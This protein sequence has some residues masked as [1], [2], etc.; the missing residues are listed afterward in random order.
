MKKVFSIVG[1]FL[2]LFSCSIYGQLNYKFSAGSGTFTPITGAS[3]FTWNLTTAN[4]EEYSAATDIGF[5]FT[6]AGTEY[7]QF[8]VSTNG[9]LRF[10]GSGLTAATSADA[11]DGSLRQIVAPLWDNLSVGLTATDITYLREGSEPNRVLTVEWKNVK[12]NK[13]ASAVN[14]QFQVKLYEG[15][16]KIEFVYGNMV[17]PASVSASIG[18]VDNTPITTAG[19]ATG[20]FL[21]I[22]VGGTA[23]ARTYHQTMSIPFSAISNAPDPNTVFTFE[24]VTKTPIAAGTYTIGGT[25]PDYKTLSDAATAL[26]V[27]GVAGPVVFKVREGT[28]DDIFHLIAVEGTSET[29]T[30]TLMNESGTVVLSPRNGSSGSTSGGYNADGIIRLDGTQYATIQ[31]LTL[32]D[33]GQSSTQLKFEFGVCVGNS[34]LNNRMAQGAKFNHLKDL[35]IDMKPTTGTTHSGAIGIRYFT[36]W[37]TGTNETDTSMTTSYNTIENCTFKGYWRAG[38][39]TFGVSGVNPDRGNVIKGCTFGD[40]SIK[41]GTGSDIRTMEIDCENGM[42]IENNTI[43]N[44]EATIMSSN[45]IYGIWFNPASSGSNLSSGKIIISNNEIDSISNSGTGVTSGVARA[46][47]I[48]AVANNTDVQIYGNKIHNLYSSGTTGSADGIFENISAGTPFTSE[49]YNNMIYDLKAPKSSYAQMPVRGIAFQNVAGN[50]VFTVYN[51]TV[52]LDNA[53]PPAVSGTNVAHRSACMYVGSF[54]TGVLDLKNNVFVNTM[55]TSSTGTGVSAAS[56]FGTS[57]SSLLLTLKATSGNNLYFADTTIA[58]NCIA[59]DGTKVYKTL[60]ELKGIAN[61]APRE[62]N[63]FSADSRTSFVS[64]VKP[65]DVHISPASWL[66][67]SQGEPNALV[68]KDIDGDV[69]STD[70]ATGPV[71]IGADEYQPTGNPPVTVSGKI[72][73]GETSTFTGVD[74]R[75]VG[76]IT[77]H[78]GKAA[79]PDSV[80]FA[81]L[82][83]T[84]LIPPSV[85]SIFKNY[86]VLTYG[87]TTG[88][89]ADLK[90]YYNPSTELNGVSESALKVH[91]KK[92]ENWRQLSSS[93]SAEKHFVLANIISGADFTLGNAA[94]VPTALIEGV[95]LDDNGDL[96]PDRLGETLKITG[97]VVSGDFAASDTGSSYYINDRTGGILLSTTKKL[98]AALSLGDSLQVTGVVGQYKGETEFV[99]ADTVVGESGSIVV[100][101]TNALVPAPIVIN[102]KDLNSE[103]YEGNLVVVRG[104]TK[105]PSSLP[106]PVSGDTTLTVGFGTDSASLFVDHDAKLGS[107]PEWL[108]DVTGIVAQNSENLSDGYRLMPRSA[109]DVTVPVLTLASAREDLNNDFIPD[110]KGQI[111]KARGVVISPDFTASHQSNN[112]YYMMDGTAGILVFSSKKLT[113]ALNIG[114]SILVKGKI[115]QYKGATEFVPLTAEVGEKGSVVVLKTNAYVPEP[116]TITVKD[117]NSE[118]YEGCLVKVKD[119]RKMISS[120]PWPAEGANAGMRVGADND[121]TTLFIDL[122]TDIDGSKEIIW[123]ANI[124][125]IVSQFSSSPSL[126]DGYELLPRKRADIDY[127]DGVVDNLSKIPA[128]YALNQNYPNPF[129]PST[130]ISFDLKSN[131]NVTLKIYSILGQEVTTLA[132][133]TLMPAGHKT[134]NFN[135]SSLPSGMYIYR[136]EAKGIDG[137]NFTGIKKMMLLK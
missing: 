24:P 77:W 113:S 117:V 53:V 114:D 6:Y 129:N 109:A 131:A 94:P 64:S 60:A 34:L 63:S 7:T 105:M 85:T 25:N 1:L 123:P 40:F 30:I 16:N 127:I 36:Q 101:K 59:Y 108:L 47:C 80:A 96:R 112:N 130:T 18:L 17:Q 21:S 41:T 31:G 124:T 71:S 37:A 100:L 28:Y 72:A 55:G 74:G 5:T 106:W 134:L 87:G 33:N 75:T 121:S 102:L 88:W 43:H 104:I 23:G 58:N 26:N 2:I 78:A 29:N 42:V 11:L 89:N 54:S 19:W 68:A 8:Q 14:A 56:C 20:K 57:A 73:D 46:I 45:N 119:L 76:E 39:K 67:K 70:P 10:G 116:V 86:S 49:V 132:N 90:L 95:R 12:W 111:L 107:E 61:F 48:N 38:I 98:S 79:L 118:K 133:G 120:A 65:Y 51:N 103:K 99:P 81:Y 15:S 115:D 91:Q 22:N 69:R 93:V 125:G 9:F 97:V 84:Q 82:P 44:I 110:R 135:A 137:S 62:S 136:L 66:V 122:D 27:N 13:A 3:Q 4:D 52:Y 50:G 83:G 35:V 128:S 92:G 32:N 126:N